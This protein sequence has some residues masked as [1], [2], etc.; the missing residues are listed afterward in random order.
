MN[1]IADS[2]LSPQCV[3][4]ILQTIVEGLLVIDQ[5]GII[6]Y[7]NTALEEMTGKTSKELIGKKCCSVMNSQCSPPPTCTLFKSGAIINKECLILHLSGKTLPVLKNARV[8]RDTQGEIIGAVETFTDISVLKSTE[9]RL[10]VL[11]ESIRKKEKYGI[12][13]KSHRMME[14]FN[15]VELASASNA[16]VL[17][18]GETGS[19]KE[20]VARAIHNEGVRKGKPFI[21]VNCSALPESLLESELFGHVKG[22]FTGAFRDKPGRFELAEGG[23]LFLDEIGELSPLIQ[24]KLLRFLQE[25]EFERVGDTKTR[26]ADVRIVAAT[27]RD[28]RRRVNEGYFREDLF[29]RLKVFPLHVPPLRERKEDIGALVEHFINRFNSETGKHITGLS[30][31]VAVTMMDYCWP[32]NVRELENAI[33]HAFVTCQEQT[34]DIFDL[35]IEIRKVELRNGLCRSEGREMKMPEVNELLIQHGK[36]TDE[37]FIRI[38]NECNGNQTEAAK[39]LGVDRTTVW[40]RLKRLGLS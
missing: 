27:H 30:H 15:L 22:A 26:K 24:V 38:L 1:C 11:E 29:Y 16:T 9:S 12:I 21:T 14:L 25:R 6:R 35:P 31:D 28:L 5:E 23:T 36:T 19:G 34:I 32:G 2:S 4:T 10:Q 33:E 37:E 3:E 40:R 8:L 7:C 17:I 39:R 18:T 20:L 13:G